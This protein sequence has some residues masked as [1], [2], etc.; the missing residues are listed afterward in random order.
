M[1][2][3]EIYLKNQS[4]LKQ[5]S[6]DSTNN[7]YMV[8][9]ET[10]PVYNYDAVTSAYTSREKLQRTPCSNDAL[11]VDEKHII[12]IEFKNGSVD[13]KQLMQKAYDSL[14]V[15]F[16]HDMGLEWCRSDFCGNISFSRKN[17]EFILVW[18][19]HDNNPET[20]IRSGIGNHIRKKGKFGLNILNGYLYKNTRVMSKMEFQ[21]E[22]IDWVKSCN[23]V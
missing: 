5:T 12:F 14:L 11:Y 21:H 19:N 6:H 9:D 20:A 10:I 4:T 1:A 16:D 13:Q 15:L 8:E 18:E 17:I 3:G 23:E 2:D 7:E 22:F